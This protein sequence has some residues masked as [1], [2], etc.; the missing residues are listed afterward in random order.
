MSA[1]QNFLTTVTEQIAGLTMVMGSGAYKMQA[2]FP[3]LLDTATAG[4]TVGIQFPAAR[5]A[6]GMVVASVAAALTPGV[7]FVQSLLSTSGVGLQLVA[8]TSGTA[9]TR[10]F[11]V[12]A[13]FLVSGSGNLL[14]WARAEVGGSTAKLLDGCEVVLWKI[15]D[16][17]G[18]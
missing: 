4:I 5:R 13:D 1:T 3:Y 9:V 11:K 18:A 7:T 12:E 16:F 15:S 8:I 2:W 10:F 6:Q 17:S 14:W